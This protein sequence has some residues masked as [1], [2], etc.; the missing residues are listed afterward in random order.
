M[1]IDLKFL[2][3]NFFAGYKRDT[4]PISFSTVPSIK[5]CEYCDGIGTVSKDEL[6]DYH[7]REYTTIYKDCHICAGEGRVI[8][9]KVYVSF[10]SVNY[11]NKHKTHY[12]VANRL[13]Y[14]EIVEPYSKE[15]AD[16]LT[17]ETK[18]FYFNEDDVHE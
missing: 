6:S 10:G 18:S 3:E 15:K 14:Q 1:T 7:K 4:F 13:L 16:S 2:K 17:V 9:S 8:I 11:N 12:S 5:S